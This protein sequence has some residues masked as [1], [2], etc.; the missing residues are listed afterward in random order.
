MDKW[1]FLEE[2]L[3]RYRDLSPSIKRV[4]IEYEKECQ[5]LIQQMTG[6]SFDDVQIIFES[7]HDIQKKLATAIYKD[8]FLLNDELQ[9]FVYHF[10]RDDIFSRK[11]W[12]QK[13]NDGMTW[14]DEK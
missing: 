14:P 13:F 1:Q 11:Y 9:A 6:K 12:Y 7:L 4:M 8:N 2:E 10:E 5:F 3:I